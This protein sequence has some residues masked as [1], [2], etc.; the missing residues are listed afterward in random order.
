MVTSGQVIAPM[1]IKLRRVVTYNEERPP[2]KSHD[3]LNTWTYEVT[4]HSK[5]ITFSPPLKQWPLN[6]AR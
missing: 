1:V 3:P 6:V 5:N 4:G 2:I